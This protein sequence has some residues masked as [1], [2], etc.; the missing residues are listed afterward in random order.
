[1]PKTESHKAN[2][3]KAMQGNT[4]AE[5]WTQEEVLLIL[6]EMIEFLKD[7]EA[8]YLDV[9]L[10][11]FDLYN[12]I[13]SYWT[14]KF[15]ENSTVFETIKKIETITRSQL[16]EEGLKAESKVN[17]TMA[18]FLLKN[19]GLSDRGSNDEGTFSG[20][21]ELVLKGSRSKLLDE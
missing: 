10:A 13:W 17:T 18:I 9:L 19:S 12:Q 11:K 6:N 4:N 16:I 7:K 5:T 15:A 1:M 2:I 3:S 20:T 21:V 14:N 8:Y